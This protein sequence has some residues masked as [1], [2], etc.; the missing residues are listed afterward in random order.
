MSSQSDLLQK[1]SPAN[2]GLRCLVEVLNSSIE[3][4]QECAAS[5]LAD[6]FSIRHDICDSL[7]TDEIVNPCIKLLTSK[8]QVV[9]IQS[10]RA[11]GALSRPNKDKSPNKTKMSYIAEGD[12]KPLIKMAKIS[13]IGSAETAVA[14]LAN[15]LSDP[16]IAEEALAEDV[17]LALTRVLGEGSLSGKKNAS[18]AL[19]QLLNHFPVGDVLVEK[20]QC[21]FVV[22]A[23]AESLVGLDSN[24][25]NISESLDV[26]VLLTKT[27]LRV[28]CTYPLW[29]ALSE[30]PTSL[31]PFVIFL[32]N[33]SPSI[34]DNAIQILSR[35]CRD[36]SVTLGKLLMGRLGSITSLVDRIMRSSSIEVKIG[37]VSLLLCAAKEYKQPIVNALEASGLLN[38]FICVLVGM[39]KCHPSYKLLENEMPKLK[40]IT[41]R[42][43]IHLEVDD[44]S[45]D[46]A[47]TLAGTLC[48]W[49]LSVIAS[50]STSSR[51]TFMEAG[52]VEALSHKLESYAISSQV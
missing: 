12:V 31:E 30:V 19:N 35:L 44:Y 39:V 10:A 38:E 49:L 7:A 47:T 11:L 28:N 46:P 20:S 9:A 4:A 24:G 51:Y 23:L 3:E 45:L 27:K 8:T 36:Q 17:V 33:G 22:L 14:A 13:S 21:Q 26:L 50:C 29:F 37:G 48:L 16:L 5:V 40:N 18:C 32:T 25:I 1:G 15:L 42:N 43:S 41:G 6:L 52:G 2:K 34:Q